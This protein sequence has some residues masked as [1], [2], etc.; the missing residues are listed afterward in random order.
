MWRFMESAEITLFNMIVRITMLKLLGAVDAACTRERTTRDDSQPL[1]CVLADSER[2]SRRGLTSTAMTR[3]SQ[4]DF[5]TS[6]G[7]LLIGAPST[8]RS[9]F[10]N[11]GGSSTG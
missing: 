2:R 6:A 1:T 7:G 4:I 3:P 8:M 11:S 10:E 9:P 5:M